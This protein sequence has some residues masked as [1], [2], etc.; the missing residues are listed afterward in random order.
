MIRSLGLGTM[1]GGHCTLWP[2]VAAAAALCAAAA[3]QNATSTSTETSGETFPP[4]PGSSESL[5]EVSTSASSKPTPVPPRSA[6]ARQQFCFAFAD[7]ESE[8]MALAAGGCVLTD[9][10]AAFVAE[11][12]TAALGAEAALEG[13]KC[14]PH[15]RCLEGSRSCALYVAVP[16]EAGE[17]LARC[18]KDVAS[19]GSVA[20]FGV[21]SAAADGHAPR[22]EE[23]PPPPL[24][25]WM[26]GLIG[27]G[28][29]LATLGG[30]GAAV[31][32]YRTRPPGLGDL[33]RRIEQEA[34]LRADEDD[35]VMM[36]SA[37]S[38]S[39][40]HLRPIAV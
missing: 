31:Q 23:P 19:C 40:V 5:A 15:P 27:V 26:G 37:Q 33:M 30:V 17:A 36:S 9:T 2:H 11:A 12:F 34:L 38:A 28:V 1:H 3:A 24:T 29:T 18:G 25:W 21:V 10:H 7:A 20:S 16:A 13:S 22:A 14:A 35:F 39:T 4:S 6:R 32:Y 8:C